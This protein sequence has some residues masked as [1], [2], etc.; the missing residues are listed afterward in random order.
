MD[1]TSPPSV[2]LL[3]AQQKLCALRAQVHT[4]RPSS[5]ETLP[6][7]TAVVPTTI[8]KPIESLPAHLG[9]GSRRATAIVRKAKRREETAVAS[10]NNSLD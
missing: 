4:E 9:W 7:E 2:A 10:Q 6:W 8:T 1:V 3:S 5:P